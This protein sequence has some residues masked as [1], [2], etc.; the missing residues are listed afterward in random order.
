MENE[1]T[2]IEQRLEALE[3]AVRTQ[4]QTIKNLEAALDKKLERIA[5]NA[6]RIRGGK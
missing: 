5:A 2:P 3:R 4:A 6:I 1:K